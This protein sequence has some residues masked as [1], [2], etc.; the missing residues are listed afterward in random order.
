MS[1]DYNAN[2]ITV[3]GCGKVREL[4][5]SRMDEFSSSGEW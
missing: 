4:Q 1:R 3:I 2:H 5:R